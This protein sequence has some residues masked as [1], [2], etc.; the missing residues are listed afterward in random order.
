MTLSDNIHQ[1]TNQHLTNRHGRGTV[2]VV[3]LLDQLAAAVAPSK[4]G[5]PSGSGSVQLP[6]DTRAL[7]KAMS[8]EA[9]ARDIQEEMLGT[10]GGTLKGIIRSWYPH[11]LPTAEWAEYLELITDKWVLEITAI[12]APPPMYR[13]SAPCPHCNQLFAGED[14]QPALAVTYTDETGKV[15]HPSMWRMVCAGCKTEWT[16]NQ[17][18]A[19]AHAIANQ[20]KG[21]TA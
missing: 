16:G 1:L 15:L 4:G 10:T 14:R 9:E 11:M 19:I 5:G 18:G 8:L 17:L 21:K 6:I 3:S 13:P 20:T 12:V 7:D 2:R